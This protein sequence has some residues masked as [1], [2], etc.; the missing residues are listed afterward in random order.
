MGKVGYFS[1]WAKSPH[2]VRSV[3]L[4]FENGSLRYRAEVKN[5][6]FL[7]ILPK[8]PESVHRETDFVVEITDGRGALTRLDPR[9]LR[10]E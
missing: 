10:W 9:W 7:L 3:E 4:V 2:G 1:G 6:R 8:R 5:G